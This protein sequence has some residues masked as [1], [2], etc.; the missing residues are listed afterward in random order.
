MDASRIPR[1]IS[2]RRSSAIWSSGGSRST[3]TLA[4]SGQINLPGCSSIPQPRHGRLP[5]PAWP[6]GL[7]SLLD[8]GR[9]ETRQQA[10]VIESATQYRHQRRHQA[11]AFGGQAF[12]FRKLTLRAAL[13]VTGSFEFVGG[14]ETQR[15]AAASGSYSSAGRSSLNADWGEGRQI[16]AQDRHF[17]FQGLLLVL[18]LKQAINQQDGDIDVYRSP[19]AV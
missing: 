16:S 13:P 9:G 7:K 2:R 17:I 8:G 11:I 15:C 18:A 12:Y 1:K 14:T 3:R 10:V 19:F 5:I 6:G 4:I